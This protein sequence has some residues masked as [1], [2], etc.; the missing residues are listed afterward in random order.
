MRSRA[1]FLM[2]TCIQAG[3]ILFPVWEHFI[4]TMGI[5]RRLGGHNKMDLFGNKRRPRIKKS[6][7]SQKT[8][9]LSH[10]LRKCLY[11]KELRHVR[12][13]LNPSHIPHLTL[14]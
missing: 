12:V 9:H 1:D 13:V 11:T 2:Q 3:N 7:L 14:T 10:F 6:I 5:N 8:S 4:P